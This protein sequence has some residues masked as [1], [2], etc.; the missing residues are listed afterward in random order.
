MIYDKKIIGG[1]VF[2]KVKWVISENQN[3]M[4]HTSH[5]S[6]ATCLSCETALNSKGDGKTVYCQN[7]QCKAYQKDIDLDDVLANVQLLALRIWEGQE[8]KNSKEFKWINA[9]QQLV[10]LAKTEADDSKYW[11]QSFFYDTN[12]GK[13]LMV[14]LGE[15]GADGKVQLFIKDDLNI[16]A[17]DQLGDLNP[18]ELLMGFTAFFSDGTVT[19]TDY[20]NK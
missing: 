14:L 15:K 17:H 8:R 6:E 10:P 5:S 13:M 7:P 18:K 16:V 1:L 19:K 3:N 20:R 11:A 12:D 2:K 4:R 9:D